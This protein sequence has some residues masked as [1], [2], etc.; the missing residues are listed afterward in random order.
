MKVNVLVYTTLSLLSW[1]TYTI[2]NYGQAKSPQ[3]T[4]QEAEFI[5]KKEKKNQVPEANRLVKKAPLPLSTEQPGAK[6]QY[7]LYDI[8]LDFQPLD[9]KIKIL[10]AKQERITNLYGKYI[11]L[12]YGNYHMP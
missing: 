7:E 4:I 6:L 12:G 11:K 5:I 1:G 3:G 2:G 10:R 8:P 9:H